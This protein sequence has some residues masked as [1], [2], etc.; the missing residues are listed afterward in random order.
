M[1]SSLVTQWHDDVLE[2]RLDRPERRNAIDRQLA[3]ALLDA[4]TSDAPRARAV[5]L[6]GG[7]R[8]FSSGGDVASMPGPAEGLMGPATRLEV[9]HRVLRELRTGPAPTVAA[10]EGYAIGAAWGLVLACDVVVAADDAFFLAP[11]ARRGLAADGAVA[12]HLTR[13]LGRQG[14]ARHL[15]LGERLAATDAR[16]AGL[17]TSVVA[18]STATSAALEVAAALAAG[19]VES[20][21][22]TRWMCDAAEQQGLETFLRDERIGVSLAGHGREAAEGHAAFADRREAAFR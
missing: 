19:P 22:V 12:W 11:F 14:A 4:L 2:L 17:V 5:V 21:A 16:A 13:A 6:T 18:P 1:S 3:E 7:D 9:I 10:V 8:H 20:T 15:L